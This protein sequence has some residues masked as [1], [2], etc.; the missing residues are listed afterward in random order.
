M[1]PLL[2]VDLQATATGWPSPSAS[3]CGA[4]HQ[5]A[6]AR[7]SDERAEMENQQLEIDHLQLEEPSKAELHLLTAQLHQHSISSPSHISALHAAGC[8]RHARNGMANTRMRH[9]P[10][11]RTQGPAAMVLHKH[12][13]MRH[14]TCLRHWRGACM[15][16][17]SVMLMATAC[18]RRY[19]V[20]PNTPAESLSQSHSPP[21][22]DLGL[23]FLCPDEAPAPFGSL[24][25]Q[26][27]PDLRPD[28]TSPFLVTPSP[29]SR[30]WSPSC[31]PAGPTK[32]CGPSPYVAG[33]Q[34]ASLCRPRSCDSYSEL[35]RQENVANGTA[36]GDR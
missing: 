25:R 20:T 36:E 35:I 27:G 24:M 3:R 8:V 26:D 10:C 16:Q 15:P 23:A 28:T 1:S 29:R 33:A 7:D 12:I 22:L 5:R 32:V 13:C 2:P 21:P 4:Q 30:S 31:M 18:L 14:R 11:V 6:V 19:P 34:C 9:W 17:L